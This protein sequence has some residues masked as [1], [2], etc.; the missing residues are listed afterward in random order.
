M[1]T[2]QLIQ[3]VNV[4]PGVLKPKKF[5]MDVTTSTIFKNIEVV[6]KSATIRSKAL[7]MRR[8]VEPIVQVHLKHLRL[9]FHQQLFIRCRATFLIH[10]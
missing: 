3:M 10:I 6:D 9:S 5:M 7:K 2:R 4:M 1:E 8:S